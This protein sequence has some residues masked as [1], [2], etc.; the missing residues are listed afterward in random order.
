[1]KDDIYIAK[2]L[3]LKYT[4]HMA[5]FKN[6]RWNKK[7]TEMFPLGY[8]RKKGRPT[9]RRCQE[10]KEKVGLLWVRATHNGKTWKKLGET[11]DREWA[12]CV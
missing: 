3:E 4:G 9:L 5:H 6:E 11:Y 1:M 10:I 8:S 2:K 12:S 7:V